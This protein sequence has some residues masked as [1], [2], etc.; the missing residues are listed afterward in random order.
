MDGHSENGTCQYSTAL[1]FEA[2]RRVGHVEWDPVYIIESVVGIK[3]KA[4]AEHVAEYL[5]ET[6]YSGVGG[7]RV[8][9]S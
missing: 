4:L 7:R 2:K 9:L 8:V 5:R 1:F 3:A 6:E